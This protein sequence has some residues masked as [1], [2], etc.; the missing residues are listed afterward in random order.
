MKSCPY[1]GKEYP[2]DATVCLIDQQSLVSDAPA[3]FSPEQFRIDMR[4]HLAAR[5]PQV[6]LAVGLLAASLAVDSLRELLEIAIH[7]WRPSRYPD[8]Y[9]R[10][11]FAFV[12]SWLFLYLIFRGKNWARWVTLCLIV[13]GTV[14]PF[15]PRYRVHWEFYFYWVIDVVAVILLFQRPS[16]QWFTKSKYADEKTPQ[17][18]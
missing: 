5:P 17:A 8:F 2:D 13:L 10:T 15:L 9:F 16:S 7:R 3:G 18:S 1:C 14:S 4:A 12:L 6:K 11:V